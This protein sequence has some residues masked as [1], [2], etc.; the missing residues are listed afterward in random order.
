MIEN[1][2]HTNARGL[3][4]SRKHMTIQNDASDRCFDCVKTCNMSKY[5]V[6]ERLKILVR[7][8]TQPFSKTPLNW[9]PPFRGVPL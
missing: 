7:K 2:S 4:T 6:Y 5:I 3:P 9:K 1:S 8:I